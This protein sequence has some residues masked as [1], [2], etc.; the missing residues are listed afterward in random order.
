MIMLGTNDEQSTSMS[1]TNVQQTTIER[2]SDII[3]M[4]QTATG[5]TTSVDTH[6]VPIYGQPVFPA[7]KQILPLYRHL[8][9]EEDDSSEKSL[10]TNTGCETSSSESDDIVPSK[11][12]TTNVM[13][14]P[15]DILNKDCHVKLD[16]LMDDEISMWTKSETIPEFPAFAKGREV[17]GYTMWNRTAPIKPRHNTRP[18]RCHTTKSYED[19]DTEHEPVSPKK[20]KHRHK[21]VPK[22]GPSAEQLA[23]Q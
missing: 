3:D 23:A 2:I 6:P 10:T 13:K 12:I 1:G 9:E 8:S 4:S 11:T 17:G 21:P 7:A 19:L 18:S 20:P 22:D 16:K 14:A 15:P 5:D